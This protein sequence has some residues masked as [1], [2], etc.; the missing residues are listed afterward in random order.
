MGIPRRSLLLSLALGAA[1]SAPSSRVAGMARK[2]VASRCGN[3]E[4]FRDV[5]KEANREVLVKTQGG[6][7]VLLEFLLE[8]SSRADARRQAE[9]YARSQIGAAGAMR[10]S[11]VGLVVFGLMVVLFP[12]LCLS[13]C[14]CGAKWRICRQRDAPGTPSTTVRLLG[15]VAVGVVGLGIFI[16]WGYIWGA[17]VKLRDSVHRAGCISAKLTLAALEGQEE[18][19]FVGLNSIIAELQRLS[20]ALGSTSTSYMLQLNDLLEKAQGI[21]ASVQQAAQWLSDHGLPLPQVDGWP[22]LGSSPHEDG[23]APPRELA[24]GLD[25]A[26]AAQLQR[27]LNESVAL[28]VASRRRVAEGLEPLVSEEGWHRV[29]SFAVAGEL[30]GVLAL[31]SS[32][33]LLAV[34]SF[35]VACCFLRREGSRRPAVRRSACGVWAFAGPLCLSCLLWGAV[36]SSLAVPMSS[37]CLV[38]GD[39][40]GVMVEGMRGAL[41]L[42]DLPSDD[43]AM[44]VETVDKCLNPPDPSVVS[45]FADIIFFRDR[46]GAMMT[47]REELQSQFELYITSSVDAITQNIPHGESAYSINTQLN[48]LIDSEII[49]PIDTTIDGMEC[50]WLTEYYQEAVWGVCYQ[51]AVVLSQL[52]KV[53][54]A[55][56]TMLALLSVIMY[57]LW[58]T[59]HDNVQMQRE[60]KLCM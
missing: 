59:A 19:R 37:T 51:G 14:P 54:V 3:E 49:T 31:A 13:S 50:D 23:A 4:L 41:G 27:F 7:N 55:L 53:H 1:G 58:R 11:P 47:V 48:E 24:R 6:D 36:L 42:D 32:A 26:S 2:A 35:L 46:S 17:H 28:A 21:G 12:Y 34:A 8:S 9:G 45:N 5:D 60:A 40:D 22:G 38:L 33:A 39:V 29:Q 43:F 57:V 10:G 52:G 56:G 44:L 20:V 30:G 18:P 16:C 25:E 15:V